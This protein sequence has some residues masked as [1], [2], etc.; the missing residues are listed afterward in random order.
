MLWTGVKPVHA[1]SRDSAVL[2]CDVGTRWQ[3][4]VDPA[5]GM[6]DQAPEPLIP[7]LEQKLAFQLWKRPP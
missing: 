7:C 1:G 6:L 3:D 5:A 4:Q 2:D